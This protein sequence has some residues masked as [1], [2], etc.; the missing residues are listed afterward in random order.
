MQLYERISEHHQF[1]KKSAATALNTARAS[2]HI[3]TT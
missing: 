2:V 1:E 3:Q